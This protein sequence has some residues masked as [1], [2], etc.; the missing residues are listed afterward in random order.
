[1]NHCHSDLKGKGKLKGGEKDNDD[2]DDV[3]DDEDKEGKVEGQLGIPVAL[4]CCPQS[5]RS[6][7][8][9]SIK[10]TPGN[11]SRVISLKM[12]WPSFKH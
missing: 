8:I 9:I 11:S 1:M 4:P 10:G 6:S 12:L 5:T 2:N 3:D 7:L